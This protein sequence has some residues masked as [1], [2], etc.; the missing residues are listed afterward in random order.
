MVRYVRRRGVR[1]PEVR[2]HFRSRLAT[3]EPVSRS[4][5]PPRMW[6]DWLLSLRQLFVIAPVLFAVIAGLIVVG[7]PASTVSVIVAGLSIVV[8][9]V[10]VTGIR[11]VRTAVDAL[12]PIAV[13]G[14]WD[15][16][17][18]SWLHRTFGALEDRNFRLLYFGN[19]AQFGSMQMQQV[20]RGW[21][22]FHRTVVRGAW[23]HGVGG[24]T[25]TPCR[26]TDR[27]GDR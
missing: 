5:V 18:R 7:A 19:L 12:P 3:A 17:L 1:L 14:A 22:V 27:W 4:Q 9:C 21:L 16:P 25:P 26:V 13:M 6:G 20:V 15:A 2:R 23:H 24:C 10:V 11:E 8:A